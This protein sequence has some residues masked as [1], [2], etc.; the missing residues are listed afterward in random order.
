MQRAKLF[1]V[2]MIPQNRVHAETRR[3]KRNFDR[4]YRM[5]RI[6]RRKGTFHEPQKI[7]FISTTYVISPLTPAPL[8][9]T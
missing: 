5:D 8:P 7:T 2:F 6:R 1:G 9:V 3:G 4:M